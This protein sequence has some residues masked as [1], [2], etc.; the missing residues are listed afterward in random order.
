MSVTHDGL[1]AVARPYVEAELARAGGLRHLDVVVVTEDD[2]RRL[3]DEVI[4]PALALG[5][6]RCGGR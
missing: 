1:G 4:V 2:A 5:R 6:G 3:V